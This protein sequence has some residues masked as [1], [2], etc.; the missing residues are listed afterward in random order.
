MNASVG[1]W[2]LLSLAALS[3]ATSAPR[4]ELKY[5]FVTKDYSI[6]MKIAFLDPGYKTILEFVSRCRCRL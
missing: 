2:M 4:N 3:Q 6:E 1:S 5:G